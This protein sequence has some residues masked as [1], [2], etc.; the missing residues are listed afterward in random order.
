MRGFLSIV[1]C[2]WD[3][4]SFVFNQIWFLDRSSCSLFF[5]KESQFPLS[6]WEHQ[7]KVGYLKGQC[8]QGM[9]GIFGHVYFSYFVFLLPFSLVD[10]YG[11]ISTYVD[12]LVNIF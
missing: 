6:T 8:K 1:Y 12:Q 4:C 5:F 11:Q 9:L 10:K 7:S 2:D 3:L